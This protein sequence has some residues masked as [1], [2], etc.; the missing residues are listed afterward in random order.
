[1]KRLE[2]KTL[3]EIVECLAI[4]PFHCDECEREKERVRESVTRLVKYLCRKI[5]NGWEAFQ[6]LNAQCYSSICDAYAYC[7]NGAF[8]IRSAHDNCKNT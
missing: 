4:F 8:V 6:Y 7:L 2:S 1:M 3:S 5:K